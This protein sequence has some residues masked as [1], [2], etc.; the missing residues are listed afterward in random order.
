MQKNV[1]NI[2]SITPA[3]KREIIHIIDERIKEAHVTKEDFSELKAIVKELADAQKRT[4]TRM[5]ELAEA[6]KRTEIHVEELADAQKRTEIRM[7]ELTEAQKQT[8]TTM[9]KGFKEIRDSISAIGSRWGIMAEDTFRNTIDELLKS[10]G[11]TV[12]C[13]MYGSREV[14]IVIRN[15]EHILLEITSSMKKTDIKKYIASAEDYE[16]K[17]GVCP[18][19]MVA[20]IYISP[21]VMREIVDAPRKIEIFSIE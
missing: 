4:G 10:A 7:E 2:R 9:S 1:K 20:A 3:M 19:I 18:R 16:K 17:T 15:G 6:Q 8:E 13:G 12:S 5:E 14:D 11:Y 21:V